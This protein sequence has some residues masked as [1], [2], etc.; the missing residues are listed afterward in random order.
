MILKVTINQKI[1]KD[2]DWSV[3]TEIVVD[4]EEEAQA[5]GLEFLEFVEAF[6]NGMVAEREE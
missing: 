5:Y 6:K 4:T 2:M 3:S 1:D